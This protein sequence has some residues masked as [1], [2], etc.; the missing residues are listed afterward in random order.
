MQISKCKF[1]WNLGSILSLNYELSIYQKEL[2]ARSPQIESSQMN[3]SE[4]RQAPA[5]V[6]PVLRLLVRA[7]VKEVNVATE[8]K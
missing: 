6:A 1:Q 2:N 4:L 8:I 5:E 7:R 3:F